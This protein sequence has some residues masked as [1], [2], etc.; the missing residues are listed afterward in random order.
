MQKYH[1]KFIKILSNF[2]CS[3]LILITNNLELSAKYLPRD[4]HKKISTL[5]INKNNNGLIQDLNNNP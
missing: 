1:F 4:F 3:P 2:V 5:E